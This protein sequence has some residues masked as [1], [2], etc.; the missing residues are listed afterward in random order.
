MDLDPI[1]SQV[2]PGAQSGNDT[3]YV[4][5]E[6]DVCQSDADFLNAPPDIG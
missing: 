3:Q 6:T 2:D 1:S 5:S 4:F